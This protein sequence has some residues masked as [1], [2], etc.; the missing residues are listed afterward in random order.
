MEA[1]GTAADLSNPE[2]E[3]FYIS[4]VRVVVRV[5][6]FLP[7][8]IASRNGDPVSCVSVL[9]RE[10]GSTEE[11]SVYLKDQLTRLATNSFAWLVSRQRFLRMF[12]LCLLIFTRFFPILCFCAVETSATNWMRSTG[13]KTVI[14][15]WSSTEK[16]DLWLLAFS[17]A[18]TPLSLHTGLLG[19]VKLTLCRSVVFW[20][21]GVIFLEYLLKFHPFPIMKIR[22]D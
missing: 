8:E 17:R 1:S 16:W 5:R 13:R 10:L 11:V 15:G 21:Q 2:R 9:D 22:L 3:Q 20:A 4:K 6:P 18:A 19:A 7:K 12:F 14:W